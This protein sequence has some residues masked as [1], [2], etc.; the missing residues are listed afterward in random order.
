MESLK[1]WRKFFKDAGTD[2]CS[3]IEYAILVAASDCPNEFRK[4]RDRIAETLYAPR[5]LKCCDHDYVT[6]TEPGDEI[7]DEQINRST[8]TD[9]IDANM[10]TSKCS[11]REAE[12]LIKEIEEESQL[13][14]EVFMIKD[15]LA[16]PNE[17][18][19]LPSYIFISFIESALASNIPFFQVIY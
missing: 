12:A 17:V 19:F 18:V 6:L 3:L 13:L 7:I 4:R 10:V 8:S 2:I 9:E 11:Y 15:I 1:E 16:N 14:K 5:F